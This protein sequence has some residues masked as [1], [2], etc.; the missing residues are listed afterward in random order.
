MRTQHIAS[1][2][3]VCE[4]QTRVLRVR[5]N[6]IDAGFPLRLQ[7]VLAAYRGGTTLVRLSVRNAQARGEVELGP[8][9]RVRAS[10]ELRQTLEKLPGVLGA[11]LVYGPPAS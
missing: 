5:L 8:E 6:G 1:I 2:N 3:S 11:E 9:W 7:G 10:S 4:R